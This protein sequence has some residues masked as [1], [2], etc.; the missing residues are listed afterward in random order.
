[1]KL[2]KGDEVIVTRGKDKGKKAKIEKVFAKEGRILLPGV[3]EFKRHVKGNMQGQASDILTL[4]RPVTETN[5]ALICPKCKKQT[6][7]GYK[8]EKDKKVRVCRKCG[9]EI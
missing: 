8:I 1:M 5:V 6:R 3:N 2:I 4:N 7:V 9:K